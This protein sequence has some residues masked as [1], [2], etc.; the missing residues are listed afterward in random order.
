MAGKVAL[1]KSCCVRAGL[2]A[3]LFSLLAAL[4]MRRPSTEKAGN[5]SCAGEDVDL[6]A[7]GLDCWT[8]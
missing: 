1:V 4:T 6:E 8:P 5:S 3:D 2:G 7:R